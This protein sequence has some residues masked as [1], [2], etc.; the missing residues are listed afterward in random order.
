MKQNIDWKQ[1]FLLILVI[2][3]IVFFLFSFIKII[4]KTFVSESFQISTKILTNDIEYSN[5]DIMTIPKNIIQIWI[6]FDQK[7][8]KRLDFPLSYKSYV[9]SI[10]E[11]NPDYN[12]LFF[13]K[14]KIE[15]FLETQYPEY[16]ITYLKLPVNIQK[17]DFFRYIAMYHFGGFYFDL[18]ITALEPLDDLLS[19]ECIFPID[20]FIESNMC[21]KPRYNIFC[22]KDM[23]FLL[24]QYA[25]AARAEHPFFKALIKSIHANV[26]NYIDVYNKNIYENHEHYVYQTTGPDF[27][28]H[29]YIKF[30]PKKSI[31]I[32]EYP[33]RQYFGKYARHSFKGSWKENLR[34]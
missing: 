22:N 14:E 12:Y 21:M 31:T 9:N 27:V 33:I 29:E 13:N 32:L 20:N 18:D 28:T 10:H 5:Q 4:N 24:G 1:P 11:I 16:Y 25:F 17:V 15:H 7:L 30:E 19:L 34:N 6:D 8:D 23:N 26:D 2:L 3:F